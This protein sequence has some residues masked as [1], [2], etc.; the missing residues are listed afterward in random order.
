MKLLKKGATFTFTPESDGI[1]MRF[2]VIA[3]ILPADKMWPYVG[4]ETRYSLK[5]TETKANFVWYAVRTCQKFHRDVLTIDKTLLCE[6]TI[7]KLRQI[8]DHLDKK[9]GKPCCA[10]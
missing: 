8:N 1:E 5:C 10:G 9:Q 3:Y 7:W 6:D 4:E 2:E